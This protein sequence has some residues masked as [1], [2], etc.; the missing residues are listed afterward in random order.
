MQISFD[1]SAL[2]AASGL[3]KFY[4]LPRGFNV[5]G[6]EII[7]CQEGDSDLVEFSWG[8]YGQKGTKHT[9]DSLSDVLVADLR[10]KDKA[11]QLANLLNGGSLKVLVSQPRSKR[12]HQ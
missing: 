2:V 10:T 3:K 9:R 8:V 4:V 1:I 5:Q 12:E 11:D 7:G 6:I